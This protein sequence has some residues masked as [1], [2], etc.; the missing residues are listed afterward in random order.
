MELDAAERLLVPAGE[1]LYATIHARLE[2][3]GRPGAAFTLLGGAVRHLAFMTCG[4]GRDGAL[5]SFLGPHRVGGAVAVVAG[6]GGSGVD[7][8]G[9]RFSH[10]H[11]AFK[12]GTGDFVGGHLILDGTI[13]DAS[14]IE[15][16]LVPMRGGRFARRFDPETRFTVFHPQLA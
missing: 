9:A 11:A 10:C 4:K 15:V 6:A 5:L 3:L 2:R 16:E 7:E 1:D 14:G 8:A 13:A 12:T